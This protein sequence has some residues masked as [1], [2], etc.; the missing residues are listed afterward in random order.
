MRGL[1]INQYVLQFHLKDECLLPPVPGSM[2]RGLLGRELRLMSTGARSVPGDLPPWISREQLY[3]Y[4]ME[5]PPPP[6]APAM[7]RYPHVPHPFALAEPVHAQDVRL[8]ARARLELRLTLFGKVNELLNVVI[9]ALVRAAAGGLGKWRARA[10]LLQVVQLLPDGERRHVFA[11]GEPMR[12]PRLV[13]PEIPSAPATA[14]RVHLITPL[15]L[16]HQGRLMKPA[17]FSPQALLM[18]LVRRY[19]MLHL[20]HGPGALQAD[21]RALK[22]DSEKVRLVEADLHWRQLSRYSARQQRNV[23]LDGMV[24][25]CTLDMSQAPDLWPYLWLGQLTH[26]GK[27]TVFGLG[28]LHVHA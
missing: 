24:G 6:D 17:T 15:R 12:Q 18:N 3:E 14:V 28:Q 5:T 16:Q 2:W 1:P 11:P 26:A 10:D 7:R 19:S 25:T 21:F 4:F 13:T 27:G 22:L 20:F 8:P 9:L 23:P